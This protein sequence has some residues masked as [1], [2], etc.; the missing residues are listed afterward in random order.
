MIVPDVMN[1]NADR[2]PMAVN[3]VYHHNDDLV[4]PELSLGMDVLKHLH[5]YIAF[6]EQA[7]YLAPA[8]AVPQVTSAK[9]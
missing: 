1:H 9:P 8:D 6:G 4:L 2:S 7:L 3:P 5:L